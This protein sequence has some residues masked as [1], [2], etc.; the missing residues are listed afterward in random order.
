M[1]EDLRK[2]L[3]KYSQDNPLITDLNSILSYWD[4]QKD[5]FYVFDG[6]L[7]VLYS[8]RDT[9]MFQGKL[10]ELANTEGIDVLD[11]ILIEYGEE[12]N[13]YEYEEE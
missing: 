2:E 5:G 4:N 11:I 7:P 13:W 6:D 8:E 12:V 3:I 9:E 1:Y 10:E